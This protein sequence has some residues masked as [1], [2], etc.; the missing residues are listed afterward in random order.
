MILL[1]AAHDAVVT[2]QS[3]SEVWRM[4]G[5]CGDA[6]IPIQC[7]KKQTSFA[8]RNDARVLVNL[9]FLFS[10]DGCAQSCGAWELV[11]ALPMVVE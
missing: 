6:A 3:G 1:S 9:L 2:D 5:L 11:I 7:G 4:E 8:F 10:I